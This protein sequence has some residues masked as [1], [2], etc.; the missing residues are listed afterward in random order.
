MEYLG[1]FLFLLIATMAFWLLIFL[2]L[3]IPYWVT[4]QMIDSFNPE[5]GERLF[6]NKTDA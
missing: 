4:L 6:G 5:L 2:V 1:V 3:F